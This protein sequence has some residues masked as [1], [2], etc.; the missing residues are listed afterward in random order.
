MK[1]RTQII[2]KFFFV[3]IKIKKIN[4]QNFTSVQVFSM[5]LREKRRAL[6]LFCV[7]GIL[8]S[9]NDCHFV[10]CLA[11]QSNLRCQ[12][13]SSKTHLWS[14]TS[15]LE[16]LSPPSCYTFR[17]KIS[18]DKADSSTLFDVLIQIENM[19]FFITINILMEY[20]YNSYIIYQELL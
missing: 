19:S 16:K 6:R 20:R 1:V 9:L 8:F 3:I 4:F 14:L 17:L 15:E 11:I 12:F 5:L 2:N 18:R 13:S 7:K 10:N